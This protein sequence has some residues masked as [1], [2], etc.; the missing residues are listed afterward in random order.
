[1]CIRDSLEHLPAEEEIAI[2]RGRVP[3]L[4]PER[5]AAM[6]AVA[7]LTRSGYATGDLSTPMSPRTVITWAENV[8]LFRD[9]A[10]AFRLTFA[11]RC[12]DDEQR[13]LDEYYQRCFD[14]DPAP[15]ALAE[16]A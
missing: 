6:V 2:V 10:L 1:M 15:R 16:S 4:D 11:N 9:P 14:V 7:A 5:A 8:A 13:V 3:S 12:D